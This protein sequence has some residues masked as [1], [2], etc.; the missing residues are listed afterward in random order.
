MTGDP[1]RELPRDPGCHGG[2]AQSAE[3]GT[4]EAAPDLRREVAEVAEVAQLA[5]ARIIYL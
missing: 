1:A 5:H 2:L 4:V 3:D